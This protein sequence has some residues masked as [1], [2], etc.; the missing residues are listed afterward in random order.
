MFDKFE[1]RNVQFVRS[2]GN[3]FVFKATP[4]T[5]Y[6]DFAYFESELTDGTDMQPSVYRANK[7]VMIRIHQRLPIGVELTREEIYNVCV[8][9]AAINDKDHEV[10]YN[11]AMIEIP[12]TVESDVIKEPYEEEGG[13]VSRESVDNDETNIL[14]R[15]E[16]REM[17]ETLKTEIRGKLD[18]ALNK[19][20]D[21]ENWL[22]GLDPTVP[23]IEELDRFNKQFEKD[24][25]KK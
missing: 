19:L 8:R 20:L 24:F 9:P 25:L 2:K 16:V 17:F 14:D 10:P 21:T 7:T 18:K 11:I 3:D 15:Y 12:E 1:L 4:F 23:N 5:N 13:S 22:N 6:K